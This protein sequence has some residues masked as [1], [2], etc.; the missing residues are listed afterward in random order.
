MRRRNNCCSPKNTHYNL[1]SLKEIK[2]NQRSR[3]WRPAKT[4]PWKKKIAR[5][6]SYRVRPEV[7][8]AHSNNQF[9]IFCIRCQRS[10]S[11]LG[12]LSYK[13]S[14]VQSQTMITM[15]GRDKSKT[16]Q[17]NWV[18]WKEQSFQN[19]RKHTNCTKKKKDSSNRVCSIHQ[20]PSI[21]SMRCK[22]S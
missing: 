21:S 11:P 1:I 15:A 6:S 20:I 9:E 4:L 18:P 13:C 22:S 3:Q 5:L 2:I 12:A 17:A 16:I 7:V 14:R 8:E 10:S 19:L